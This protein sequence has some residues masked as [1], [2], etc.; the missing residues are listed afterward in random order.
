MGFKNLLKEQQVK[1]N[2]NSYE[3]FPEPSPSDKL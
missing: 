3:S 1:Q 2:V